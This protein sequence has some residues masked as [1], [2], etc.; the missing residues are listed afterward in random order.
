MDGEKLCRVMSAGAPTDPA[1][2]RWRHGPRSSEMLGRRRLAVA[3]G[4]NLWSATRALRRAWP[5]E[6]IP[7]LLV[8]LARLV[9]K[10]ARTRSSAG[11]AVG[12]IVCQVHTM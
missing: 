1:N 11:R 12:R 6:Y 4:G 8:G 9:A 2:G 10:D 3:D 5:P 7:V